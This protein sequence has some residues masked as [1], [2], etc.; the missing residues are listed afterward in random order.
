MKV[1]GVFFVRGIVLMGFASPFPRRVTS[2]PEPCPSLSASILIACFRPTPTRA[3]GL[4]ASRR[5]GAR[6]A[7]SDAPHGP[8]AGCPD[9]GPAGRRRRRWRADSRACPRGLAAS[10]S[11][12]TAD[13]RADRPRHGRSCPRASPPYRPDSRP[14][15]S[16]YARWGACFPPDCSAGDRPEASRSG[17]ATGPTDGRGCRRC[18]GLKP[19]ARP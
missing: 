6:R 16:S 19:P 1:T 14:A 4:R 13:Q 17:R 8:P 9:R 2:R 18:E 3:A 7:R 10:R 15:D 12:I 11:L 5:S